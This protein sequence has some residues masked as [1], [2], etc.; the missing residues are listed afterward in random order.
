MG[1]DG[2]L[3]FLKKKGVKTIQ[4]QRFISFEVE[5]N[6]YN[7]RERGNAIQVVIDTLRDRIS[8]RRVFRAPVV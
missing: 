2:F 6:L 7:F 4:S 5:D 3:E 1:V 8:K